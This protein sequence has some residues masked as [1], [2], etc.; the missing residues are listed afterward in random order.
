MEGCRFCVYT[1]GF[2]FAFSA[3]QFNVCVHVHACILGMFVRIHVHTCH[4][5]LVKVREQCLVVESLGF[6]GKY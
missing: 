2:D 3:F 4:E 5:T 6:Q 1:E